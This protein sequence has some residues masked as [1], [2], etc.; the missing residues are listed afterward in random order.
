[1]PPVALLVVGIAVAAGAAA[2]TAATAKGRKN[3]TRAANYTDLEDENGKKIYDPG[4]FD[5]FGDKDYDKTQTTADYLKENRAAERKG[6][7]ADYGQANEDRAMSNDART[8]QGN[9]L[10]LYQQAALGNGPSAAQAQLTSGLGQSINANQAMV[11]SARGGQ[12][13]LAAMRAAVMGNAMSGQNAANQAAQLRAQEQQAG[14]AGFSSAANQMRGADLTQMGQDASMAQANLK[15]ESEQRGRNDQTS[16]F[17]HG[18]AMRR[19][20]ADREAKIRRQEFQA[21]T[22]Q[23]ADQQNVQIGR[24]NTKQQND[25]FAKS[26][27]GM[28]GA[29]SGGMGEY[30]KSANAAGKGAAAASDWDK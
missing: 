30:A 25:D 11:A 1:M 3:T 22:H 19:E 6:P 24:D 14:M 20:E 26:R 10:S 2:A 13:G 23:A 8:S 16:Q 18:A 28:V 29:V 4:A 27:D 9:A 7:E 21:Q 12:T 17:Y 5:T 15:A